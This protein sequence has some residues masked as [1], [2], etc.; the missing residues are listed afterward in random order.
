MIAVIV[1][2][3][4]Y[5]APSWHFVDLGDYGEPLAHALVA[6]GNADD[7][8]WPESELFC[9]MPEVTFMQNDRATPWTEMLSPEGFFDYDRCRVRDEAAHTGSRWDYREIEAWDQRWRL[10]THEQLTDIAKA[11]RSELN[12]DD[13]THLP[14]D[15]TTVFTPLFEKEMEARRL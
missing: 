7:G 5:E 4:E 9:T 8:E 1:H 10:F 13:L 12:S 6:W 14:D 15:T 2:T 3:W 11:F